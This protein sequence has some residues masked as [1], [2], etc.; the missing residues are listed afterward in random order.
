MFPAGLIWKAW[1][2]DNLL[3]LPN[4]EIDIKFSTGFHNLQDGCTDWSRCE[5]GSMYHPLR[6]KSLAPDIQ[7]PLR[8]DDYIN[9]R[10]PAML[11]IQA[12]EGTSG[13]R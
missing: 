1:G 10:D 2:E 13:E 5:W 9:G 3:R 4:S 7:A 8:F 11:A 6:F 12:F